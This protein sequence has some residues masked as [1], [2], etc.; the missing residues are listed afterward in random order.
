M[1]VCITNKFRSSFCKFDKISFLLKLNEINKRKLIFLWNRSMNCKKNIEQSKNCSGLIST[2]K[3]NVLHF[4][5]RKC[6]DGKSSHRNMHVHTKWL[7]LL[8]LMESG[9]IFLF[10]RLSICLFPFSIISY[11][12]EYWVVYAPNICIIYI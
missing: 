11:L 1:C 4:V 8:S 5:E 6:N 7:T 12:S 2:A 3:L 10:L 9:T